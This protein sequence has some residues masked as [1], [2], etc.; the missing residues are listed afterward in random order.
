MP[1]VADGI[2]INT[3]WNDTMICVSGKE[4]YW[5]KLHSSYKLRQSNFITPKYRDMYISPRKIVAG[6][7]IQS[8]VIILHISDNPECYVYE[9][10]VW[11][12]MSAFLTVTDKQLLFSHTILHNFMWNSYV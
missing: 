12:A 5:F 3:S 4:I 6:I 10:Y 2:I 1:V 7:P 9:K 11:L 8:Y